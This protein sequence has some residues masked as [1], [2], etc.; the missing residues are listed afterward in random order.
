MEKRWNSNEFLR[1]LPQVYCLKKRRFNARLELNYLSIFKHYKTSS[2][3]RD[4]SKKA[5]RIKKYI[6][7]CKKCK[8]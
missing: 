5:E 7:K 8:E 6:K 4:A 3:K 1:Y 2:P